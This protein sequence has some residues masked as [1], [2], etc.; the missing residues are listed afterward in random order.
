VRNQVPKP[1]PSSHS[2]NPHGSV[3]AVWIRGW[4]S[5]APGDSIHLD[6]CA[7]FERIAVRTQKSEYELVVLPGTPGEVLV[8]GGRFFNEFRPAAIAGSICGVSAIRL[9]TIE[10]GGRL[11]LHAD[12]RI[13]VTS[14][15]Q[16]VS[17]IESERNGPVVM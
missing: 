10:V 8:R 9:R 5:D 13:I 14:V 11:E 3:E 15:I 7:P 17:R 16:D 4:P 1:E 6:T 12:G 2:G